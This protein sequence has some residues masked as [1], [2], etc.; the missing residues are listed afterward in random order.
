MIQQPRTCTRKE[1]H[2]FFIISFLLRNNPY[3]NECSFLEIKKYISYILWIFCRW[4]RSSLHI[5]TK[6]NPQSSH[7]YHHQTTQ[8]TLNPKTVLNG[9][10]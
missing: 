8:D 9:F 2:L 4:Y 7:L 5:K 1:V 6:E 10:V 3:Y